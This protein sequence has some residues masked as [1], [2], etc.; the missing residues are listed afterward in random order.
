MEEDVYI[1]GWRQLDSEVELWVETRPTIRVTGKDYREAEELLLELIATKLGVH[2]A[3]LELVPPLPKSDFEKRYSTP[4]LLT[5]RGD[6]R[7]EM[8]KP[9]RVMFETPEERSV[10]QQWYD[11]FFVAPCCRRCWTAGGPR[12]ETT[13]KLTH[14][15]G[16]FDGG[17]VGLANIMISIYSEEFLNLLSSEE[18]AGLDLRPVELT[19]QSRKRFFELLGPSGPPLVAL[20]EHPVNGW[21]CPACGAR[22]FGYQGSQEVSIDSFIAKSDLPSPLPQIF[23]VGSQ[24]NVE[25]CVTAERWATLVGQ[26]GTR[27]LISHRVGA[28]PDNEVVREPDLPPR[29][30]FRTTAE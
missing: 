17:F 9:G 8:Y 13:L 5:I 20:A 10:R 28:A 19:R 23:T 15:R 2:F 3:A 27:G 25:L 30:D 24:P 18:R 14:F 1:C 4:K 11:Q 16:S 22:V 6:E 29:G 12:N 26:A 21:R 7:F